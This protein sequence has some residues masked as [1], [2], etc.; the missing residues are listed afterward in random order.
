MV[1]GRK[2]IVR[3]NPDKAGA[4][5]CKVQSAVQGV[6]SGCRGDGR[7]SQIGATAAVTEATW[8]FHCDARA[9]GYGVRLEVAL[10]SCDGVWVLGLKQKPTSC[11]RLRLLKTLGLYFSCHATGTTTDTED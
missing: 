3:V 10:L 2:K 9:A 5:D 11:D 8:V 1:S 4:A 6:G 7:A